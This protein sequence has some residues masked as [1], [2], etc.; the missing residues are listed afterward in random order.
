VV[1]HPTLYVDG[2][3]GSTRQDPGGDR[4]GVNWLAQRPL[5]NGTS[6]FAT[7]CGISTN[8]MS[9][10]R[11]HRV[12][13]P[14]IASAIA[15]MTVEH[16]SSH[17]C[18]GPHVLLLHAVGMEYTTRTL[19]GI[20]RGFH[21]AARRYARPGKSA[22]VADEQARRLR[23]RV[24]ALLRSL[25][26]RRAACGLAMRGGA[27]ALA[28]EVSRTRARGDLRTSITS[29]PRKKLRALMGRADGRNG[30]RMGRSR[31]DDGALVQRALPA[32]GRRRAG[33]APL[34]RRTTF[35][36][37]ATPSRRWRM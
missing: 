7:S 35:A 36:A 9:V 15:F 6:M 21:R 26:S 25:N 31:R 5:K 24:H 14:G 28:C 27:Q 13:P 23:R 29:R 4:A 1:L 34:A 30:V 12:A 33:R 37:G 19:A 22:Y 16:Q 11:Q 2:V 20:W 3:S 8:G 17:Q 18:S 10:V 32:G